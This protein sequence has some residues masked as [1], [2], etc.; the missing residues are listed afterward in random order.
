MEAADLLSSEYRCEERSNGAQ[1]HQKHCSATMA[2]RPTPYLITLSALIAL[3][4]K[5]NSPLY[6]EIDSDP[7][8]IDSFFQ[9]TLLESRHSSVKHQHA[10]P[11]KEFFTNMHESC[12]NELTNRFFQYIN[13][14]V[15]SPDALE[16]L[17]TECRRSSARIDASSAGGLLL[18]S[19]SLGFEELSFESAAVLWRDFHRQ[20]EAAESGDDVVSE[21]PLSAD[22]LEE[23]LERDIDGEETTTQLQE[24]LNEYPELPAAHFLNFLKA[25]REGER[26]GAMDALHQYLDYAMVRDPQA[27]SL[28]FAAILAA[29]MHDAFGDSAMAAAATEEA[30]RVAQQSQDAACVAFALGWLARHAGSSA[31]SAELIR[32]CVQRATEGDLRALA[33]GANLT[34]ARRATETEAPEAAWR[35]LT[36]ASTDEATP[37]AAHSGLDRPTHMQHLRSGAE[38]LAIVGRQRLVG[39]G[40][41][42]A[43]SNPAMSEVASCSVLECHADQLVSDDLAT[44]AQNIARC[45]LLGY[46]SESGLSASD[47]DP[48]CVY[49]V[50][51]KRLITLREEYKLPTQ[52]VFLPEVALVLHE[53]AVRRGDLV[54]AQA[55][56]S[57]M[58][59]HLCPRMANYEDVVLDVVAQKAFR[60][61]RQR[62]FDEAR[63]LLNETIVKCKANGRRTQQARLLLQLA[64]LQLESGAPREFTSVLPSLLLGL[65][66]AE[67][68][69]MDGL[70]AAAMSILGQVHLRM[71][72]TKRAMAVVRAALPSVLQHEHVWFQAEARLTMAKCHLEEESKMSDAQRVDSLRAA[73]KELERSEQLFK[74]CQDC[75]R[76][77]AVYY[78]QARVYDSMAETVLRD[79]SSERFLEM[80]RYLSLGRRPSHDDFVNA[81]S[82]MRKLSQL[83]ARDVSVTA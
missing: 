62:R 31:G 68:S 9:E 1:H 35:A 30:V 71:G 11:L 16:D 6:E 57:A 21:W 20:V 52:G 7:N 22:Q 79:K 48:E 70:H 64:M 61:S 3:H 77:Q 83:V 33:A 82:D 14:A 54:H 13:I 75:S 60:L 45:A 36:A 47:G 38:A 10:R 19:V 25:M 67:E 18:R 72:N 12:G 49:G 56:G 32:R 17:M 50:A 8:L 74:R 15:S 55:L 40:V 26:E 34:L 28:Q 81:V 39:A 43:F 5:E 58:E 73:R 44:A 63:A 65:T 66:I 37:D 24:I 76:L 23:A 42:Q 4:C 27:E 2:S 29:S 51:L 46:S 78:L 53:W 80:G 41:W 59:S 69:H